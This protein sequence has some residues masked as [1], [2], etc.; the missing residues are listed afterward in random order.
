MYVTGVLRCRWTDVAVVP[1][2]ATW[3]MI[4]IIIWKKKLTYSNKHGQRDA[5]DFFFGIF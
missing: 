5:N 4:S 3:K 2:T 1:N